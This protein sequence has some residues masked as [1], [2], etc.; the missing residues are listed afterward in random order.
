MAQVA[1][2]VGAGGALNAPGAP[3]L[4]NMAFQ[5][6]AL[7]NGV[8]ADVDITGTITIP[9]EVE[10]I[11]LMVTHDATVGLLTLELQ[12]D[13]DGGSNFVDV[14]GGVLIVDEAN[15]QIF[16]GES[17]SSQQVDV[18]SIGLSFVVGVAATAREVSS[19]NNTLVRQLTNRIR[20]R[21]T[22]DG[23]W[24]GTEADVHVVGYAKRHQPGQGPA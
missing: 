6:T 15:E 14:V 21:A 9:A 8:N 23:T 1:L 10:G 13:Q 18:A 5:N 12:H 2:Q 7:P 4:R 11:A 20:Y 24:N 17:D 16:Y 3:R 19:P 22:T